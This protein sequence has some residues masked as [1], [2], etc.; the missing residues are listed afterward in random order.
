MAIKRIDNNTWSRWKQD[1]EPRSHVYLCTQG[2]GQVQN[3]HKTSGEIWTEL[4]GAWADR[5]RSKT[6][7]DWLTATPSGVSD[8][9]IGKVYATVPVVVRSNS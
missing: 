9:N 4:D 5:T 2:K 1:L 7:D 8:M 6:W 3:E